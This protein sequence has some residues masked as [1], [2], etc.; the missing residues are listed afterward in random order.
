M[1]ECGRHTAKEYGAK[2]ACIIDPFVEIYYV[3]KTCSQNE[4]ACAQVR[5]S[6][7]H[8]TSRPTNELPYCAVIK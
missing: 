2:D 3:W 1:L 6:A 7:S 5:R 8:V 4:D